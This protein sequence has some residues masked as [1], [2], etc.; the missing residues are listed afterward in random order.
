MGDCVN[1][2]VHAFTASMWTNL[3]SNPDFSDTKFMFLAL[4]H[5]VFLTAYLIKHNITDDTFVE[6]LNEISMLIIFSQLYKYRNYSARK[7]C[8]TNSSDTDGF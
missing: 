3:D 1:K 6:S 4:D 2:F 7:Q 8:V 5:I